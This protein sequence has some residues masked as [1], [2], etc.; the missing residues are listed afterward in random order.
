MRA[1]RSQDADQVEPPAARQT[2]QAASPL[3]IVL[4]VLLLVIALAVAERH[5]LIRLIPASAGL[6]QALHLR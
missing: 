5:L 3:L 1:A 4:L 2:R 6:F